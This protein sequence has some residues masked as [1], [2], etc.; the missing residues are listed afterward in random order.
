MGASAVI[1][2]IGVAL[3]AGGMYMSH[4]AQRRQSAYYSGMQNWYS[5]QAADY[6][7]GMD[8]WTKRRRKFEFDAFM[9]EAEAAKLNAEAM[10]REAELSEFSGE[11]NLMAAEMDA[12]EIEQQAKQAALMVRKEAD[13][14]AGEQVVAYH[15]SG[16]VMA[17]T[18]AMVMIEDMERAEEDIADIMAAGKYDASM[19]RSGGLMNAAEAGS[20]VDRALV[21]SINSLAQARGALKGAGWTDT[22]RNMDAWNTNMRSWEMRTTGRMAGMQSDLAAYSARTGLLMGAGN[23]FMMF[24]GM[25]NR[26]GGSRWD[27]WN[28]Y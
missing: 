12:K 22:L 16:V 19:A 11:M 24:G 1:A 17:G 8:Y 5:Q 6:K 23:M 3:S 9:D 7:S 27:G 21:G 28:L 10:I 15:S 14:L 4:Q 20:A 18:P 25:M 13:Q 26:G 2:G